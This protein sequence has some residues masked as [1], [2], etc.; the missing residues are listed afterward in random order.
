MARRL[1]DGF[2][3]TVA[4]AELLQ[5]RRPQNAG[6]WVVETGTKLEHRNLTWARDA[7]D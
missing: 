2:I 7:D 1:A 4:E 5:G 3:E 6:K